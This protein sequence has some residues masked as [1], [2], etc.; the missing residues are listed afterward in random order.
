MP[1]ST[2]KLPSSLSSADTPLPQEVDYIIVGAGAA[3]CVLAARLTED[4]GCSVL[5]LEVGG[6]NDEKAMRVPAT[7]PRLAADGSGYAYGDLTTPQAALGGRR[8]AMTT[9]RGLGGGSSMNA[10]VWHQGHPM[11]YDSWRDSGATGWGWSDVLPF[12]RRSEHHELGP[13]PFHGAGGPMVITLPRDIHPLTTAFIAASEE[14]GVKVNDD[15]NGA[16]REGVGLAQANIRD[17]ARHSVVDGYLEPALGRENLTVHTGVRVERLLFDGARAVGVYCAGTEVQ[18][19][20]SVILSAGALRT[21]QLLMVSGIGPQAHLHE[22]GIDVVRDLP[23][24]GANLQDQPMVMLT[25][26]LNDAGI[27]FGLQDQDAELTY[28]LLRRG[29]RAAS[30]PQVTAV[31]RTDAGLVAPDLHL[32]LIFLDPAVGVVPMPT[33]VLSCLVA[34]LTPQSRGY[35]RL[36]SSD[37]TDAP[38]VD[39]RYL[40]A[41]D[42]WTRLRAGVQRALELF[43]SPAL[44]TVTGAPPLPD[45]AGEAAL[46]AFIEENT[47]SYWHPVGTARMGT[48]ADSV[49]DPNLAVHGVDGLHVVDA[50]VMPTITRANTQA[51][52]IAIAERAAD[53][54]RSA[55]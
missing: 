14:Q 33:P 13:G 24:V 42:D 32:D 39:P 22:Y 10:M 37:A 54:L 46:N 7:A 27:K 11:D 47:A 6:P 52:T 34:L 28:R 45:G 26:P 50:S 21:P 38:V 31:L 49:V 25:W 16:E 20:S 9:G 8:V 15:L 29:P 40:T 1:P 36:G 51:P 23:G 17:G 48:D 43:N 41:G 4:P 18:A 12:I 55:S 2:T 19:R 3:G 44:H 30:L 53:L 35:V 5:L